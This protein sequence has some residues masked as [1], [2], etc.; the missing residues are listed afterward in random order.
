MGFGNYS[1]RT[2]PMPSGDFTRQLPW[3]PMILPVHGGKAS[4]AGLPSKW[5]CNQRRT[6]S[7]LV[8]A[9]RPGKD[10]LV[11]SLMDAQRDRTTPLATSAVA[12]EVIGDYASEQPDILADAIAYAAPKSFPIVFRRLQVHSGKAVTALTA[13]LDALP[14]D[15]GEMPNEAAS[16]RANLAIAL[17]RFNAG[18][19]LWPML[20]LCPDPRTRSFLIDRFASLGCDP[21]ALL[22]RLETEPDDTIRAALWLGLGYFNDVSLPG[23]RRAALSPRLLNRPPSGRQRPSALMLAPYWL[24][25]QW[26]CDAPAGAA[27]G[28][29]R[30]PIKTKVSTSTRPMNLMKTRI[31]LNAK[32][33]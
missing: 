32:P 15:G 3:P 22:D 10:R 4:R 20:K 5:S 1:S 12:A 21:E 24:I 28:R 11:S 8:D 6:A 27:V 13:L 17:L 14:P 25:G 7:P 26:G 16:Q 31:A 33:L 9:L 23:A 29:R 30:I 19:R 2:G 18:G